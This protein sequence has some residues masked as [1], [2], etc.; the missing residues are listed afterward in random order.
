MSLCSVAGTVGR[1]WRLNRFDVRVSRVVRAALES[2]SKRRPSTS[3]KWHTLGAM[4]GLSDITTSS[5]L[6]LRLWE[7]FAN[8]LLIEAGYE[9]RCARWWVAVGVVALLG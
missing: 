6:F 1:E 8:V 4:T 3:S 2:W 7:H 5:P 9:C